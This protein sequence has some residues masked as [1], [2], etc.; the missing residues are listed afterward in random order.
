[1]QK[2]AIVTGA[3]SGIGREIVRLLAADGWDILAVARRTERL[4][5]LS[6]ETPR[7]IV[8]YTA[9]IT[10]PGAPDEIIAAAQKAFGGL[11][12]LV[13]NAGGSKVQKVEDMTETDLDYVFNLNVRA[14]IL[15]CQKAI[16]LLEKAQCGQIINI[17]SI[18]AH[19]PMETIATYCAA[20][21]AVVMFSRVLAKELA[22]KNIRVNVLSPCGT[23]SEIYSRITSRSIRT[24]SL[25]PRIWPKWQYC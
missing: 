15:L 11:D 10:K 7:R 6:D 2:R 23:E 3:S 9:D 19:I 17:A 8:A 16:P 20:K 24:C 25:P 1:M 14:L 5:L 18:A 4:K 12:L 13:N 22:Q 21:S